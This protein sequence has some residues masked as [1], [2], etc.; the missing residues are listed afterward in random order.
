MQYICENEM[1]SCIRPESYDIHTFWH[2]HL[3]N[4]VWHKEKFHSIFQHCTYKKTLT[5]SN[6]S[7]LTTECF[8][9]FYDLHLQ[10]I[11]PINLWNKCIDLRLFS[12]YLHVSLLRPLRSEDDRSWILRLQPQNLVIISES[13]N[14]SKVLI[15]CTFLMFLKD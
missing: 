10:F 6:D 11:T 1:N 5:S 8:W 15:Y 9:F 7:L 13:S 14:G 4:F 12:K 3:R 2:I